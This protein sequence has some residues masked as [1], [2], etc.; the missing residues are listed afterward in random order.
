MVINTGN[1]YQVDDNTKIRSTADINDYIGYIIR[2]GYGNDK[3]SCLDIG[4]LIASD[5]KKAM[6]II[7]S[8]KS[9]DLIAYDMN[10]TNSWTYMDANDIDF[11]FCHKTDTWTIT[12][13]YEVY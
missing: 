3:E 9:G 1:A 4:T 11:Q 6:I 10:C 7:R 8:F 2:I 5:I 13:S 12:G